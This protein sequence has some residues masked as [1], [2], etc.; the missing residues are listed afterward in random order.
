[1]AVTID[2]AHAIRRRCRHADDLGV[3]IAPKLT[4]K[5]TQQQSQALAVGATLLVL[6]LKTVKQALSASGRVKSHKN[7][8][9]GQ[10][11]STRST[12]EHARQTKGDRE[13]D[14]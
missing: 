2:S 7:S 8:G 13:C 5:L 4:K 9:L 11:L 10:P 14:F 3:L 1:M 6:A 12:K